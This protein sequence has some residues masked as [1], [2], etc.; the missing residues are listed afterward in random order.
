MCTPT[1]LC[2]CECFVCLWLHMYVLGCVSE[3]EMHRRTG[4]EGSTC[5]ERG[6][7]GKEGEGELWVLLGALS[8]Q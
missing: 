1:L 6:K 4:I 7:G 2:I 8:L 3:R 5:K